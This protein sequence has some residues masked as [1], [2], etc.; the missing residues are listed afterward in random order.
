MNKRFISAMAAY[1]VLALIA[2]FWLEGKF[3]LAVMGLMAAL[4]LKTWIARA[5]RW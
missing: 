5:A 4:A 2:A 1:A 3:R